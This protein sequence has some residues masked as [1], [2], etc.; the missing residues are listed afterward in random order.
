MK[1]LR[2]VLLVLTAGVAGI[3]QAQELPVALN[4]LDPVLLTE[5]IE[6]SGS[7][8]LTAMDA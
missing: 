3:A 8:E 4:G 7:T 2:I 1:I 5:G 6:E